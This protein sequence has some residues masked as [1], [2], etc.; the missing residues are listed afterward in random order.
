MKL[1]YP[2]QSYL[3]FHKQPLAGTSFRNWIHV[4]LDNKC[5]IDWQFI[6]KALYVTGMVCALTPL[7]YIEKKK[8]DPKIK[9]VDVKK[10]VFIIGHWRSGTTFMHYL[11]GHDTT[12][13]YCSTMQTLDPS[14]FLNYESLLRKIVARRLPQVRPMDN[15]ELQTDLPY[16]DEY[17]I[18]NL[19]PYSFYHAWYFPR[20]LHWYLTKYVLHEDLSS[21]E[22]EKWKD[23]YSYFLQKLTYYYH[24]KQLLIKSLVNTA[25]IKILLEMYPDA[26]FI[27]LYRNPYDVYL[28][29]W[30]LY[31]SILPDFSF[32]HIDKDT[33][34][35]QILTIYK[36]M[37][38]Q[39]FK[40]RSLIPH[41]NVMEISY[42]DFTTHPLQTVQQIYKQ[43][44]IPSFSHAKPAFEQYIKSHESYIKN[45]HELTDEIKDKVSKEWGFV[46]QE[47]NY[48]L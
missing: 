45:N 12:L 16:E 35:T 32:Q 33:L 2:K 48:P 41:D 3:T 42:E 13:G 20:S 47:F 9:N 43:F 18:A 34:D 10:P 19:S 14:I 39:Y 28:S 37:Y 11:L 38:Q 27:H 31:S 29:T 4:L 15:L 24:G 22:T 40:Q 46:F 6:P 25:K 26:R 5:R 8:F 44:D 21:K 17:A 23:V 30:K 36:K 7:R 1:K